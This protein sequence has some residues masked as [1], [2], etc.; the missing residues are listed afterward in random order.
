MQEVNADLA[1]EGRAPLRFGLALH[2]G[3]LTYGNIGGSSR[4]DFTVIGPATNEAARIDSLTKDLGVTL[5]ISEDFA[6]VVSDDL[7]SLGHHHLRG[8]AEE[9][10]V[11]TLPELAPAPK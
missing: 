11:F 9:I 1:E 3:D 7:V 2:L 5:L 10:E 6:S 4:L 8:V